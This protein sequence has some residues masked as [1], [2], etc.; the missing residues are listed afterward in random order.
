MHSL[1]T[2][3]GLLFPLLFAPQDASPQV[4]W[5]DVDGDARTDALVVDPGGGVHLLLAS[6]AGFRP[7]TSSWGLDGLRDVAGVSVHGDHVVVLHVG[8]GPSLLKREGE[9]YVDVTVGS[10]LEDLGPLVRVVSV[11]PDGD[12]R[13]DLEVHPLGGGVLLLRVDADSVY[14]RTELLP[15][16]AASPAATGVLVAPGLGP[17]AGEA[18]PVAPEEP[19]EPGGIRATQV[20]PHGFARSVGGP[21]RS[22]T[23]AP[24][25]SVPV[26]IESVER[27]P[28]LGSCALDLRDAAGGP[29]IPASA[30]ATS[31]HLFP[32]GPQFYIDAVSGNAGFGTVTPETSLHVY[33]VNARLRL[34]SFN[35]FSG[36]SEIQMSSKGD[37]D[38][39]MILRS[40]NAGLTLSSK[41]EDRNG[42]IGVFGPHLFVA[43]STSPQVGVGTD[44]PNANLDVRGITLVQTLQA[45][46]GTDE[47]TVE[48]KGSEQSGEGAIFSLG[49]EDGSPSFVVDAEVGARS[50]ELK[51]FHRNGAET[52]ELV[53]HNGT[54]GGARLILRKPSSAQTL[55]LDA[56]AGLG[57]E[58]S[59]AT[60]SGVETFEVKSSSITANQG[61]ELRMSTSGGTD[62]V[63]I[64]ASEGFNSGAQILLRRFDGKATIILDADASG[65]GLLTTNVLQIT[66]GSD[67]VE[68]FDTAIDCAPGSVVVIDPVHEGGLTLSTEPYDFRVAGVVSGAGGVKPGIRLG[69]D[70]VLDG[71]TEVALTGRVYVRCSAE[72]GAIEAGHLLTTSSVAGVAMRA[73]DPERS[74]GAVLGKAMG[75]LA[76]GEG[77]VLVLVN[78]Q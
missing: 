14:R 63:E 68:G 61:A 4:H 6:D 26:T 62:T 71:A 48:L 3:A 45:R 5:L 57:S 1:T 25:P 73:T 51:M 60:S 64:V 21:L 74:N 38:Q 54:G 24:R 10:G 30:T 44:D 43:K 42:N 55:R 41:N 47:T 53:P 27:L 36:H 7:A 35:V 37:M 23:S 69:Q 9:S 2:S 32:L 31:G 75:S 20:A 22:P 17:D 59:M 28:A 67:L 40:E 29:C 15:S 49:L 78:L 66:G 39:G 34:S 52:V 16:A 50:S 58:F 12:G 77:L 76:S 72:N 56:D 13:F 8:R 65:D 70:G 18:E 19:D 46:S 11:D 33:D